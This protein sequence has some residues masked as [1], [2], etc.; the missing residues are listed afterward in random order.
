MTSKSSMLSELLE[1]LDSDELLL[2][3][4]ELLELLDSDELL[5]LDSD[6]L[7]SEL[8]D[9]LLLLDLELLD[10]LLDDSEDHDD[11]ELELLGLL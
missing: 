4:D 7:L 10:E 2:D 9:E 8:L 5:L 11:S 3:S 6:E 1:L